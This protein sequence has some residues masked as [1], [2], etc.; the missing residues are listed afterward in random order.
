M[1]E[2]REHLGLLTEHRSASIVAVVGVHP[3]QREARLEWALSLGDE[4]DLTHSTL[5]EP[6]LDAIWADDVWNR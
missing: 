4:E 2:P 5:S 3:L 6:S 1:R